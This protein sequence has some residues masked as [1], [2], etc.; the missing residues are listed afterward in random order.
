[1]LRK[2]SVCAPVYLYT[3]AHFNLRNIKILQELMEEILVFLRRR[4][5]LAM[6]RD[7]G[8]IQ[9]FGVCDSFSG[10]KEMVY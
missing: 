3:R 2:L 1:M 9:K 8:K 7:N 6:R 5:T 4:N 10:L